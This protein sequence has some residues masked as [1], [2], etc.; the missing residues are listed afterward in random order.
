MTIKFPYGVYFKNYDITAVPIQLFEAIF[1]FA[2][3]V[4]FVY[5]LIKNKKYNLPLYMVLY[6]TWRFVIEYFRADDRGATVV[7]FLTPSQL[8]ALLMIFGSL[9]VFL[10]EKKI[11]AKNGCENVESA[12]VTENL[13][14]VD[15]K[16]EENDSSN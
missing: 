8:V 9:A 1:L 16:G 10:C 6:G 13:S 12:D 2:L 3:F 4:F 5:R 11:T 7:S 14:E 15:E